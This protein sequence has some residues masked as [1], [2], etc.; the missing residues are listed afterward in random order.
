M[1]DI[2]R[3]IQNR[4]PTNMKDGICHVFSLH[5]TAGLTINENAD[6][7]VKSDIQAILDE[8]IPWNHSAY[9]H[10]EG[11]SAAHL[12]ASLMGFSQTVPVVN[13]KLSL[14]T[15]QSVYFC[16]FDGPRS[17]QVHVQFIKEYNENK[18]Q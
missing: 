10:V 15:W 13:G 8:I 14:G 16:E 3:D 11:N 2:T 4:V 18:I 12:K 7:D 17:R 6:P 1:V 5:T 9:R